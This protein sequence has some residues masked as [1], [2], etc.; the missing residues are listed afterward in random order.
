[1]VGADDAELLGALVV[2]GDGGKNTA[3]LKSSDRP[4]NGD[5]GCDNAL[6]NGK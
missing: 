1:M 5:I 2:N 3:P 6:N 4:D